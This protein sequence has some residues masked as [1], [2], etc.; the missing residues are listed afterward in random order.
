MTKGTIY[1]STNNQYISA[2]IEWESKPNPDANTSTVTAS[3]YYKRTNAEY[4]TS[5]TGEF[6]IRIG[7][8]TS[9]VSKR[10][11]IT[12]TEWLL[13]VSLTYIVKHNEDGT[14]S[15]IIGGSGSIPGTTLSETYCNQRVTL[16]TIPRAAT[17]SVAYSTALGSNCKIVWTPSST[18]FYYKV[19]FALGTYSFTTDAFCPGIT[20]GYT[21]TGYTIPLD[22]AN[23]F[24]NAKSGTM[25]ATLY[26]YSDNGI[27]QVGSE[28]SR[29]FTVEIPENDT[30]KPLVKMTLTAVNSLDAPLSSLYLQ[31]ISQVA[32]TFAGSEGKY[33]AGIKAYELSSDGISATDT[34]DPYQLGVFQT[35]GK[36]IIRG[37]ATDTRGFV[38]TVEEEITVIPYSK[39]YISPSTA[40]NTI[41]CARCDKDGNLADSGT[42]LKIK[43]KRGYSKVMSGETTQNN[44]CSIRYRYITENAD[45]GEGGWITLLGGADTSRDEIDVILLNGALKQD[46]S[47]IVQIGAFDTVGNSD[48]VQYTIP[49]DFVTIDI[50]EFSRGKRIGILRYASGTSEPGVDFGA[51]IHG[52]SVDSLKLGEK[53]TATESVGIDLDDM[54]TPGCYYSPDKETT[55]YIGNTPSGV[56]FG[57]GLEIREMQSEDNIRQTLYYGITT[58]YRHCYWNELE[59]EYEWSA[60]VSTIRGTSDEVIA[61]DFVVDSGVSGLWS[62]R[63]WNSG[64]AELWGRI[65]LDTFND[66]RSLKCVAGLPFPFTAK[67]TVNMTLSEATAY[68]YRQG[69]IILSEVYTVG[70]SVM[71]LY[72]IRNEGGLASGNTA[73]VSVDIKG[74]WK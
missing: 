9:T 32:A 64:E 24:P 22:V 28:S 5:G 73:D 65:T 58:W 54:R 38:G 40:M 23:N 53:I 33:G 72:M 68:T 52:G 47:Y 71:T 56:D 29:S 27:T 60:W 31:G 2:R 70:A 35:T 20:S 21:Y 8:K 17:I 13:A 25:T 63:L 15:I 12:N 11:I 18:A 69:Q 1:G 44:F 74:R 4:I 51:P 50:P 14:C 34:T 61:S 67:P 16:D 26:T 36:T 62:Y 7:D 39:P 37:K 41:V 48:V 6:S 42:Y 59:K 30:T 55:K 19:R 57:F 3:L 45:F 46:T 66:A 49:T 10:V 43:A